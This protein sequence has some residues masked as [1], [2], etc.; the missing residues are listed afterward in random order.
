MKYD[1]SDPAIRELLE[2]LE[3]E[4]EPQPQP[5]NV[6]HAGRFTPSQEDVQAYSVMSERSS[7]RTFTDIRPKERPYHA[8]GKWGRAISSWKNAGLPDVPKST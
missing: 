4:P 8:R 2:G 7:F 3:D 1:M 5:A 6:V